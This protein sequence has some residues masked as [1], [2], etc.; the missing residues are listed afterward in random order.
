MSYYPTLRSDLLREGDDHAA[1]VALYD[2]VLDRR[3]GLGAIGRS[4]LPFLDGRLTVPEV[5]A[6]VAQTQ[7]QRTQAEIEATIRSLML[8]LCLEG[9]G[10]EVLQRAQAIRFRALTM[11]PDC[12]EET[13]V[14]CQGSGACCQMYSLGPLTDAD[15]ARLESLDLAGQW[16]EVGPGPYVQQI[17]DVP[18]RFLKSV[19]GRCVFLRAD[20]RCGLHAT[21]GAE[22]KPIACRIFPLSVRP[23]IRG[24]RIYDNG[25]C[26]SAVASARDGQL[27][28][29]NL[30]ALGPLLPTTYLEHPI[31][32]LDAT[33]PCDYGYVLKLSDALV[34]VVGAADDVATGL[35]QAASLV[36]RW[37]GALAASPLIPGAAESVSA[38]ELHRHTMVPEPV[39]D[40]EPAD[41]EALASVCDALVESARPAARSRAADAPER[42]ATYVAG[43]FVETVALVRAGRSAAVFRVAADEPW[44][45]DALRRSLRQRLYGNLILQ[46][47]HVRSGF[48]AAALVLL[49]AL[50]GGR[51]RALSQGR[52]RLT[53][54]DLS[55]GL[56][57]AS[58]GLRETK[59]QEALLAHERSGTRIARAAAWLIGGGADHL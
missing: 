14:Q 21:F 23:T 20:R 11:E 26:S 3:V 52:Q 54:E 32:F 31:A 55:F 6:R 48:A 40:V 44:V 1:P 2:P 29:E 22:S 50:I 46:D 28:R 5:I 36:D 19:G 27:V 56:S 41:R 43:A 4:L 25:E 47:G 35:S 58:V 12:L 33:T 18:G 53:P 24:H 7:P 51:A 34:K 10:P 39:A 45:E 13:R 16:P 42:L 15:V 17:Q 57:M 8:L 38:A 59:A 37:V 9:T 30:A 49:F